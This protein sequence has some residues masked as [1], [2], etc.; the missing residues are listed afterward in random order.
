MRRDGVWNTPRFEAHI[1]SYTTL[2]NNLR[3]GDP[4]ADTLNDWGG[5]Y[6]SETLFAM[7]DGSVRS[8]P[9]GCNPN[10]LIV[11]NDGNVISGLD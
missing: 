6:E 11:V 1:R 4:A 2:G 3:D 10:L 8:V 7:C 9:F 5:P